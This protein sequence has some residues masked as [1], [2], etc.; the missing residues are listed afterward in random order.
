MSA[1]IKAIETFQQKV[2][3]V[4]STVDGWIQIG[5]TTHDAL[6]KSTPE[7]TAMQLRTYKQRQARYDS[8]QYFA[9]EAE[10]AIER[11]KKQKAARERA[12]KEAEKQAAKPLLPTKE[13]FLKIHEDSEDEAI[14]NELLCYVYEHP[15]FVMTVINDSG[16]FKSDNIAF[17]LTNGIDDLSKLNSALL[18]SLKSNLE[19]GY[20]VSEEEEQIIRLKEAIRGKLM[21]VK[22]SEKRDDIFEIKESDSDYLKELKEKE[23]KTYVGKE[24]EVTGGDA[25][26]RNDDFEAINENGEVVAKPTKTTV[27]IVPKG[28]YK[29]TKVKFK[30]EDIPRD[31]SGKLKGQSGFRYRRAYAFIES[32]NCWI[33]VASNF[34]KNDVNQFSGEF[35][36]VTQVE[37]V[38]ESD[39]HKTVANRDARIREGKETKFKT[40]KSKLPQG[41][42]VVVKEYDETGEYTKVALITSKENKHT[43]S[44]L[45]EEW[46]EGTEVWTSAINLVDG[47]SDIKAG[48]AKWS[49]GNF[50]GHDHVIESHDATNQLLMTPAENVIN[51]VAAA[52][53]DG[54]SLPINSGFR[55]YRKQEELKVRHKGGEGG[56]HSPARLGWS[57]HQNGIAYD[58]GNADYNDSPKYAKLPSEGMNAQKK[59][60]DKWL[61]NNAWKYG[62]VLPLLMV[63]ERHHW[64]FIGME[65]TKNMDTY[66]S[67][68][69]PVGFKDNKGKDARK[70]HKNESFSLR[71]NSLGEM[72]IK[73][74]KD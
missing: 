30:Y 12:K 31:S 4:G 13:E 34:V 24:F 17:Y 58:L 27:K 67:F 47:W 51:M 9:K 20:T 18:L 53:K 2:M 57:K 16:Y 5:G 41:S 22:S 23:F 59:K 55:E 32:E 15:K 33:D 45:E 39:D 36:D 28:N 54:V 70:P 19:S 60:T 37:Y 43:I 3:K 71:K 66:V 14:A 44:S 38:S 29:V 73:L 64:E 6:M 26:A 35:L 10:K 25:W 21:G 72:Y 8:D 52:E 11:T 50:V 69:L 7:L 48:T 1:T 42:F 68:H 56:I 62:F 65:K 61:R 46:I 63:N 40:T 49:E 74:E